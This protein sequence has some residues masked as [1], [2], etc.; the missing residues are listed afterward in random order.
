MEQVA[1]LIKSSQPDELY[2]LAAYHHSSQDA[3]PDED[4]LMLKSR[5][6]HVD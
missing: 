6:V 2:Y 3:L 1:Q 4:E 5:H